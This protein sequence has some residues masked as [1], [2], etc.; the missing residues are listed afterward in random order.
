[1]T[2]GAAKVRK[3]VAQLERDGT[4]E[5]EFASSV[6]ATEREFLRQCVK[7]RNARVY[8]SGW[9]DFLLVERGHTYCVEVKKSFD[10][11]LRH[12]QADMFALL[13][14]IGL[15]VYVWAHNRPDRLVHWSKWPLPK[16]GAK[17]RTG[18]A[19]GGRPSAVKPPHASAH[20]DKRREK[21]TRRA[22]DSWNAAGSGLADCAA[23]ELA[24]GV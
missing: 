11:P 5:P 13:E 22:G 3:L 19:K 24:A 9:P 14:K 23:T 1:M 15:R 18:I 7:K 17:R 6:T 16:R 12:S 8:R 2:S 21:S 4:W 20:M 10:E